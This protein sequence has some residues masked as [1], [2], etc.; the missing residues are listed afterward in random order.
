MGPPTPNRVAGSSYT[1]YGENGVNDTPPETD[2]QLWQR[3]T[4]APTPEVS[5]QSWLALQC[6]MLPDVAEGVVSSA[7]RTG[8]RLLRRLSGQPCHR[9]GGTW[10]RSRNAPCWSGM[11]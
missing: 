6:R 4:N 3:F 10:Q 7:H 5:Y 9:T 11:P 8:G 2:H 1:S